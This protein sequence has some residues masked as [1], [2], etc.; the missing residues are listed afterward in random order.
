MGILYNRFTDINIDLTG[1][2][3]RSW[4][5]A[6]ASR[7]DTSGMTNMSYMFS[8][9]SDAT[10]IN[11]SNFDTSN[12]TDMSYM[13]EHCSSAT[14]IDA[15]NFNTSNVT[16]MRSMFDS[17]SSATSI[18]VSSFN[19]ANVTNMRNMFYSCSSATLIDV[20][21][22]DPS[23]VTDMEYMFYSCRNL[24]SI[25]LFSANTTSVTTI[26]GL[27][28]GCRK[29]TTINNLS[30]LTTSN[31]KTMTSTFRDIARDAAA[32]I[33]LDLSTFRTPAL[34]NL[35]STFRAA[36][37]QSL[38]L[39]NWDTSNVT[40]MSNM[41]DGAFP[42]GGKMWVPSTFVAT[43]TSY[44]PFA[45]AP[46]GQVDVYTDATDATTQGW[47]TIDAKFTMHYNTTHQAFLNA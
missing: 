5:S 38:D 41:L 2:S 4:C 12:V 44:K 40:S 21:G 33:S 35:G 17:C 34:L 27:F 1:Y 47:G 29:L 24:T 18:D 11:V 45:Y 43:S 31:V 19:T 7:L 13:F 42:S 3:G 46:G 32:P 6:V 37:L 9:Q 30:R 22:F 14:S 26:T 10:S 8:D 20:S 25:D 39:D 23:N 16:T 15:S 28:Y 36:N